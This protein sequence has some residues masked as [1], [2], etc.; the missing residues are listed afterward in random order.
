MVESQS[1]QPSLP[2]AAASVKKLQYQLHCPRLP[3]VVYREVAAHLRL[4][5]GV[6]TGLLPQTAKTFDYLQSPAGGMWIRYPETHSRLYQAQVEAILAYYGQRY[7]A[8]ETIKSSS[9]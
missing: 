7:G 3:L 6:E 1:P 9:S 2:K 4:I 8:W 5:D